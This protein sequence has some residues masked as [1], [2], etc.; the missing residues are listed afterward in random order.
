MFEYRA[1]ILRVHDGDTIA[2]EVDLGFDVRMRMSLRLY[3]INAPELATYAG[4]I[5]RAFVLQWL[6]DHSAMVVGIPFH[7]VPEPQLG[8][9]MVR[10]IK[11]RADKYGRYLAEVESFDRAANLNNELITSGNA[12]PYM[13]NR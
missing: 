1:A 4:K 3:G 12:V 8:Y 5:A 9:V 10:T 13:V 2:A 6:L 11:D 7:E